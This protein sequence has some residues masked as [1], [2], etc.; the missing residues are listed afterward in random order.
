MSI[1][2]IASGGMSRISAKLE[3]RRPLTRVT[4]RPPSRPRP[5]RVCGAS[6]SSSSLMLPAP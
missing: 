1:R 3:I 5:L 2:S 6:A 4:G